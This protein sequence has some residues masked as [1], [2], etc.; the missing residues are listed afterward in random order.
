[1]TI[2]AIKTEGVKLDKK[3]DMFQNQENQGFRMTYDMIE[4]LKKKILKSG[5]QFHFLGACL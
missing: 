3:Q 2:F 4:K 1:M 5:G